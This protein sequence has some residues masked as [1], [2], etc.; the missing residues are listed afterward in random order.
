MSS[1][2]IDSHPTHSIS[3]SVAKKPNAGLG[4]FIA[5]ASGSH[6]IRN[7]HKH[8]VG[9]H[10]TSDQPVAEAATYTTNKCKE[11]PCPQ[12]GSNPRS[13]QSSCC[14]PHGYQDRLIFYFLEININT[15]C[16]LALGS[17]CPSEFA[18]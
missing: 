10:W 16:Y 8:P 12:W 3:S 18:K 4:S 13:P 9:L 14:R 11:H 5:E 1:C 6:T 15:F 17:H 7:T 2:Q